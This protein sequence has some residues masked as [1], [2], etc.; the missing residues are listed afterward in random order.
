MKKLSPWKE[1]IALLAIV[2]STFGGIKTAAAPLP[3]T[4]TANIKPTSEQSVLELQGN[5][6]LAQVLVG[7]CRAAKQRIFVYTQRS[8]YSQTIRTIAPNE[9]VTLAD[10]GSNGW[11]A[12]RSPVIGYVQTTELKACQQQAAPPKTAPPQASNPPNS[13][14][15]S[16]LCR[17]VTY[18]DEEVEGLVIRSKPNRESRRVSGVLQG[19]RVTLKNSPLPL[20]RDSEGRSWAEITAPAAGWISLGYPG[21]DSIN[22]T[23]CS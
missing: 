4:E 6:Q 12:I 7:Q 10:S 8:I 11:I 23:S 5:W 17:L 22:L 9:V 19:E 14:P 3:E 13:N 16:R 1:P 18:K 2:L 15:S 21:S 20:V